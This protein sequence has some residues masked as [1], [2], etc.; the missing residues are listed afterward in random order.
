MQTVNEAR[1]ETAKLCPNDSDRVE[2]VRMEL[3]GTTL[4]KRKENRVSAWNK[5]RTNL[6]EC[7]E[8]EPFSIEYINEKVKLLKKKRIALVD[9]RYLSN[10]LIQ[11]CISLE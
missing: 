7:P 6:G 3:R 4:M 5:S 1:D 2:T 10:A 11:V 8:I 9:Y